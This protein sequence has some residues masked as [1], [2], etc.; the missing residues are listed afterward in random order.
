MASKKV[1]LT[2]RET[3]LAGLVWQ[4]FDVEPKVNYKKLAE[5]AGLKNASTASACWGPVKKKLMANAGVS[6]PATG[7]KRGAAA[8][9]DDETH[10]ATPTKKPARAK[11]KG[12]AKGNAKPKPKPKPKPKSAEFVNEAD[13]DDDGYDHDDMKDL[14][15][16][17][18]AQ[19]HAEQRDAT[20]P[21]KQTQEVFDE[22]EYGEI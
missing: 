19:I 20:K 13:E 17:A 12:K 9:G 4:C 22:E 14:D 3:E 15:I 6:T 7:K 8:I 1:V 5:V 16:A 2:A 10:D 18:N 11:A 21:K